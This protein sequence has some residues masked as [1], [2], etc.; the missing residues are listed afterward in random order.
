MTEYYKIFNV[1]QDKIS[2]PDLLLLAKDVKR[3]YLAAL[4]D[5]ALSRCQRAIGDAVNLIDRNG[6]LM[7]FTDDLSDEVIDILSEWMIVYWLKPYVN[8]ADHLRN[9]LITK[10]FS[11]FSPADLLDRI[12]VHYDRA[13][14]QAKSLTNEYSFTVSP[15]GELGRGLPL[16]G[17][18]G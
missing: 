4:L 15:I 9:E 13:Y 2:D 3:G 14:R 8:N 7:V 17:A 12:G 16:R 5:R 10:D 11:V 6:E 1:F 18:H